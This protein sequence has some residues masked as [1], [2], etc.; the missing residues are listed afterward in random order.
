MLEAS[1]QQLPES[2][3][4]LEINIDHPLVAR[5]S[6]E[7]DDARFRGLAQILLDHAMLAEG[8]QLENPADYVRR[9]NQLLLELD[10]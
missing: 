3:P 9:M 8:T 6:A 1:G 7:T 10:S 2:R 5:L 4:T